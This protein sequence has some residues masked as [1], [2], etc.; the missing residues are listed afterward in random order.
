LRRKG[1]VDLPDRQDYQIVP[2]FPLIW[3]FCETM[4]TQRGR[5]P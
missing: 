5:I 2:A 4:E 3:S 1:D